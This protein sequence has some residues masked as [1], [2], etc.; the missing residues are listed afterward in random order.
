[1]N[2]F[3]IERAF[4]TKK[5][6]G[7]QK[8]YVVVDAHGTLI[9]PY[10]TCVEIYPH[11]V[12]VMR[13]FNNRHDIST[14]LWTS[15][16][17]IEI[18]SILAVCEKAN[19]YFNSI[20]V[21]PREPNSDRACFDQKFYFNILLDDKAGFEPETDWELIKLELMRIGEWFKYTF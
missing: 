19:F 21:N 7:W 5:E 18:E 4:Q 12:E 15:S 6:R 13:W 3:N 1:M 8:L 16:H 10:H 9:K 11:A 14:I 17:S 20:N 2:V